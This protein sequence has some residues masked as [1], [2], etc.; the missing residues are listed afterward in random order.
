[1][2][3]CWEYFRGENSGGTDTHGEGFLCASGAGVVL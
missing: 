3:V 2:G 1:M